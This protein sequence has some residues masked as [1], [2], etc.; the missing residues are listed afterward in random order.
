M[1]TLTL[2]EKFCFRWVGME[3][4]QEYM[5]ECSRQTRACAHA[6]KGLQERS[7]TLKFSFNSRS[8]RATFLEM[9]YNFLRLITALQRCIN[10]RTKQDWHWRPIRKHSI[11]KRLLYPLISQISPWSTVVLEV[12]TKQLVTLEPLWNATKSAWMWWQ[13]S[14][15]PTWNKTMSEEK[16]RNAK[17][18]PIKERNERLRLNFLGRSRRCQTLK[19]DAP[20]QTRTETRRNVHRFPHSRWHATST[21]A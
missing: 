6:A 2:W 17:R 1:Q 16:H 4:R 14:Y 5:I 8:K 7:W 19:I 20:F 9:A 10:L 21:S 12:F 18:S 11:C 13:C 15:A 3:R